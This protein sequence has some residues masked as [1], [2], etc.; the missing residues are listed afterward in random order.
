MTKF[1]KPSLRKL[2][3]EIN[4]EIERMRENILK[5]KGAASKITEEEKVALSVKESKK[6]RRLVYDKL[7]KYDKE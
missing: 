6:F 5:G 1:I 2:Y 3:D 4:Q 7:V